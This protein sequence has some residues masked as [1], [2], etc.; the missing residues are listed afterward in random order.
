MCFFF[1]FKGNTLDQFDKGRALCLDFAEALN[2]WE[3]GVYNEDIC[4]MPRSESDR[5]WEASVLK[6]YKDKPS[7]VIIF[8]TLKMTIWRRFF[9]YQL[10]QHKKT[11]ISAIDETYETYVRVK[12]KE[13]NL[14]DVKASIEWDGVVTKT[15]LPNTQHFYNKHGV[16]GVKRYLRDYVTKLDGVDIGKLIDLISLSRPASIREVNEAVRHTCHS[17]NATRIPY[18]DETKFYFNKIPEQYIDQWLALR[19]LYAGG[20]IVYAKDSDTGCLVSHYESILVCGVQTGFEQSETMP[21]H[22]EPCTPKA[23]DSTAARLISVLQSDFEYPRDFLLHY[24]VNENFN[25]L[26]Y[27][28]IICMDFKRIKSIT[29]E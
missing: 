19:I 24:K 6:E 10:R 28:I 29:R 11:I 12:K 15:C 1:L 13:Q 25:L 26:V 8:M 16:P 23:R 2:D 22:V 14:A 17:L 18:N 20:V 9:I 5:A 21:Q 7:V 4:D 3:N 27:S